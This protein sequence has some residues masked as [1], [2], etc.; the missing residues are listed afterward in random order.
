MASMRGD[1]MTFAA[2]TAG[3]SMITSNGWLDVLLYTLTRRILV[4]SNADA[5][6]DLGEKRGLDTF[7]FSPD[8]GWGT[9]TTI[10]ALKVP[11][12]KGQ[13]AQHPSKTSKN[14]SR[15]LARLVSRQGSEE[16]LWQAQLGAAGA[17]GVTKETEVHVRSEPMELSDFE[18]TGNIMKESERSLSFDMDR[19]EKMNKEF[20]TSALDNL[21]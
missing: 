14:G 6:S 9:T 8:K 10:T 5:D 12:F 17:P 19:D 11:K 1:P 13:H 7:A 4:L 2:L 16:E 21:Q 20:M 18:G 15:T 3:A